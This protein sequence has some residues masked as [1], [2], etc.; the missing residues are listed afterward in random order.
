MPVTARAALI[1]L[2]PSTAWA[3]HG[4]VTTPA[5][6][7]LQPWLL[8]ALGAVL[9]LALAAWAVFAPDREEPDP[10]DDRPDRPPP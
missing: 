6:G 10:E 3:D 9:A 5:G 1:A 7:V 2:V 8:L 4:G